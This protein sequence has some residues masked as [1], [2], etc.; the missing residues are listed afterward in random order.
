MSGNGEL[1]R[2]RVKWWHGL[3][4]FFAALGFQ[5]FLVLLLAVASLVGIFGGS[6]AE[7]TAA[8]F[9]PT[10]VSAQVVLT[11]T[12]LVALSLGLP[13][14]FRVSAAIWLG[15]AA[16]RPLQ[17]ALSLVGIVGAGVLV[18]QVTFLLH[19]AAPTFFDST[20]LDALNRVF[21]DA[22]PLVF[23]V[24]TLIISV[25][26]GLGE[27]MFFRGI[28]LRSFRITMPAWGAVVLS[29]LLFAVLHMN[30]LQGVGVMLIGLYL[31]FV[32]LSTGSVWPGVAAH[33]LNNLLCALFARYDSEGAG[34]VWETGHSA[35]VLLAAAGV[36]AASVIAL[37]ACRE[38]KSIAIS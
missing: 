3:V 33:T 25:G 32:A 31:G 38:K 18:D 6:A 22:S 20:G 19:S 37:R 35:W 4:F 34:S 2:R 12:M 9:S 13:R 8:M 29:S 14:A 16:V 21:L 28:I 10:L 5:V 17:I 36:T 7:V 1:F 11:S 15:F 26:P 23:A 24:L 27:E 30:M